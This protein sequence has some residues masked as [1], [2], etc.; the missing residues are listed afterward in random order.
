MRR[1]INFVK[2]IQESERDV[3]KFWTF[4]FTGII[5]GLVFLVWIANFGNLVPPLAGADQVESTKP[6]ASIQ[7]TFL[8]G[9]STI[10]D[11]AKSAVQGKRVFE[12]ENK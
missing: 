5:G 7:G 11:S 6:T 8:A 9:L 1:F 12:F 10:V 2:N 4:I 3:R